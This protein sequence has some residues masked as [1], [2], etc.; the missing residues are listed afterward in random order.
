VRVLEL[1]LRNYRVFEEVELELPARVIGIFGPNGSGKTTL[2]ESIGYALYGV[3]AARTKKQG[4]RTQGV[5]TDCEVRLAFEHAGSAYEVRRALRG[6][7]STPEAELFGGDLLLASGTTDVDAEI[8]RLLHMDLHV[9]RAS[10]FAEQKQLDAFSEVTAGKRK[11]MA[12]RLLGIKPVDD[13]RT[14]ARKEARGAKERAGQLA[15]AVA[16]VAELEAELKGAKGAEAE[17]RARAKEATAELKVVA[18]RAKTARSAFERLDQAR[19]R[20]E[21]LAVERVARTD[22]RAAVSARRDEL[23][24]RVGRLSAELAEL[25]ELEAELEG[26]AGSSERLAAAE[27]LV[28]ATDRLERTRATLAG[29]PELD[30]EAAISALDAAR[31]AQADA[32]RAAAEASATLEHRRTSVEEAEERLARASEADPSEP[33]P[34]CGRPL[35]E[36][37]GAYVKHCRQEQAAAKKRSGE[38][39]RAAKT[40]VAALAK[41]SAAVKRAETDGERALSA[42]TARAHLGEQLDQLLAEV[43]TLAEPFA[44]AVPEVGSL[45]AD[46]ARAGELGKRVAGLA[47]ERKHLV[48]AERDVETAERKLTELD[49]ALEKLERKAAETAFDDEAFETAATERAEVDRALESA[50]DAERSAQDAL[51]E[52]RQAVALFE[53]E[54][55]Q[56]RELSARVGEIR[57]EARHVERVSMLLDGFRDHLVARVGPDLSREAE[58]LFR[59]LTNREYA[60]L[61]IAEETLDIEIADGDTYHPIERFSGSEIDLANLALR[62]AISAHLSRMSG[63]DVGLLV[64]DEVLASLDEE[65]KDLMVQTLGRLAGRFHQLVVITHAER[66]KDQFPATIEVSRTSR[67]PRRSSAT[68][69]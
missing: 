40:A 32:Q 52:A 23:A 47:A 22:E 56:A 57:S 39:Q 17:A 30:A 67:S 61:R 31:S 18:A 12:L 68:L 66:V 20:F 49:A 13:A 11:E 36:D 7:G 65:R 55:K 33:C 42:R 60:D 26:L 3:E 27:Q 6:K 15:E 29:S 2:V 5:L 58:A 19:Q 25:P 43:E 35:G 1:S 64:L 4:I 37:F 8:R 69:I 53:G 14:T 9:F 34:T 54:L 62:V 63:A 46:V 16:D 41:A 38:A 21:K 44:G 10:V 59:D 28:Q 45:R 50:Q 51:T 24:E 48:H